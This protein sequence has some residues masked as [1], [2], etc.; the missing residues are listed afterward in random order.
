MDRT[1]KDDDWVQQWYD[2]AA[3]MQ[4]RYK[5]AAFPSFVFL[6]PAAEIVH[7]ETGYKAPEEFIEIAKAALVPGK[8]Y[9]NPFAKYDS[10]V[11]E[12]RK[13][14]KDYEKMLYM[15]DQALKTNDLEMAKE[16]GKQYM[17]YLKASDSQIIYTKPNISFIAS[18]VRSK[19][20]FFRMFYPDGKRVDQIMEYPGYAAKVVD[21]VIFDEI[22]SQ[23]GI[24]AYPEGR[25]WTAGKVDSSEADWNAIY[26][27]IEQKFGREYAERNIID[28]K[29][30]WYCQRNNLSS[31]AKHFFLKL[32]NYGIDSTEMFPGTKDPLIFVTINSYA[33]FIFLLLDDKDLMKEA[34]RWMEYV[35]KDDITG[36]TVDTYASLLYKLGKTKEAVQW[37]QKALELALK[38][39]YQPD[40]DSLTKRLEKMKRGEVTWKVPK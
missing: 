35:I 27:R 15:I 13:G 33:W 6:S 12:Y 3:D 22:V 1:K 11:L 7:K 14:H 2:T 21:R 24:Q 16:L 26:S 39:N 34:R 29:I 28:A 31:A 20:E 32:R 25:V 38:F 17:E 37:E 5:I 30:G 18:I 10:L 9:N 8:V 19:S 36:L 4:Q 23:F 40:I